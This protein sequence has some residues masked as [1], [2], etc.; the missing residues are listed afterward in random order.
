MRLTLLLG[1]IYKEG[2]CI[3]IKKTIKH[4]RKS[5]EK[6]TLTIGSNIINLLKE[7]RNDPPYLAE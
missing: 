3:K 4:I 7:G 1:I 2:K 6:I 5:G